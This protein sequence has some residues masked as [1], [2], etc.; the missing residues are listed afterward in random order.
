MM[1]TSVKLKVKD[2]DKWKKMFVDHKDERKEAGSK[3]AKIFTN[4]QD[5]NEITVLMEVD[6]LEKFKK[7]MDSPDLKEKMKDSGMIG[8]PEI[9]VLEHS[10]DSDS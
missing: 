6:N 3:G 2:F 9:T 4:P 5:K 1:F 8:P 10:F 7:F